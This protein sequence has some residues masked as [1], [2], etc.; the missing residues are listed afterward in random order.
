MGETYVSTGIDESAVTNYKR[1]LNLDRSLAVVQFSVAGVD[2]QRRYFV[3]Y[4]DS[5]MVWR[6]TSDGGTQNLTFRFA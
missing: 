2:Y 3:S 1:I 5:V 6:F 4:P